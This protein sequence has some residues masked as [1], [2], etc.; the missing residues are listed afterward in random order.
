MNG[1]QRT[2]G[3]GQLS[4]PL[5]HMGTD[6]GLRLPDGLLERLADLIAERLADASESIPL[7]YLGVPESAEYLCCGE[8]RIYDLKASGRLRFTK[9]GTRLLFR[10]EWLD[11]CLDADAAVEVGSG[12]GFAGQPS[13]AQ[14]GGR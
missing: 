2:P 9:D 6:M 12:S 1:A 8:R 14:A 7:G 3:L 11:D 10:R 13:A 5:V 4:Q